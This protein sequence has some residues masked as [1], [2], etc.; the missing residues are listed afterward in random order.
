MGT[1]RSNISNWLER[2]K[3]KDIPHMLVV[4]DTFDHDDYP[5]YVSRNRN[6]REEFTKKDGVNM[7]KV[8]EVYSY[9]VNLEYQLNERKAFHFD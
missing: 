3:E 4:C 2:S 8:M 5:A 9:N 6:A 7:Q 1:T